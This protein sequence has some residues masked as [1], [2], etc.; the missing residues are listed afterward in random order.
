MDRRLTPFSGR[1]AHISLQGQIAAESFTA[2]QLRQIT[3]PLVDLLSA[4]NGP[5][6]RQ[7]WQG[8]GFTVIDQRDGHAFGFAQKDGY[9]GWLPIAAL[10][11]SAPTHW[12]AAPASH[13][14]PE[15]RVQAREITSLPMGAQ[16]QVLGQTGSF[17]QTPQGFIPACHLLPLGQYLPDPVA[18]AE[19][20]L[21]SP[22]LWGGNSRAGIDCS[23]LVQLALVA[24]G[25]PSAPDADLQ[26]S[27]G[28][29]LTEDAALQRGDLLF[30]K[31]HVA[32][33]VDA[34]RLIHAN[35]HTMSVAYED[36]AACIARIL[37]AEGKPVSHRRRITLRRE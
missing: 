33:V 14:Y 23:G 32:M 21:G 13:L 6:D 25:L 9:C 30:W 15:P 26:Q 35:G 18:V 24:C 20:L 19:S 28:Q 2:G 36:T 3:L 5:R 22:Y 37:A 17:A 16:L 12:L 4:P 1:I 8:E 11:E 34:A 10:G 31:G 27:L 29:P 7:L